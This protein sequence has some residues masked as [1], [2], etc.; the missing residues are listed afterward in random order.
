M[1]VIC[2]KKAGIALPSDA[3]FEECFSA[4]KTER[5]SPS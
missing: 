5:A 3:I 4:N 2:V 1:C